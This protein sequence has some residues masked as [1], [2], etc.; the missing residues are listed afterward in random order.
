MFLCVK[1]LSSEFYFL[2]A[3][4]A[5]LA[6][7]SISYPPRNAQA[8]ES[9][10]AGTAPVAMSLGATRLMWGSAGLNSRVG[11]LWSPSLVLLSCVSSW[12]WFWVWS[13]FLRFCAVVLFATVLGKPVSS[14]RITGRTLRGF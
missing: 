1:I 6:P 12:A 4:T 5:E 3:F 7:F 11:R 9:A 8:A 10:Y 13:T 2:A 14:G